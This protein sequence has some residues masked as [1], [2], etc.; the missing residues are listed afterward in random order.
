MTNGADIFIFCN[1]PQTRDFRPERPG[2]FS[3]GRSFWR[4]DRNDALGKAGKLRTVRERKMIK[5]KSFYRTELSVSS[6]KVTGIQPFRPKLQLIF[7][8]RF[9]TDDFS[10]LHKPR[11]LPWVIMIFPFQGKEKLSL[12]QQS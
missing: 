4:N 5:T 3:P 6:F 2:Y 1:K 7:E 8:E 12:Y 11:A 10:S 9:H